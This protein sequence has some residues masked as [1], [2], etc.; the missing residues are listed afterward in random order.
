MKLLCLLPLLALAPA[1]FAAPATTPAPAA[2]T[3][4]GA[5]EQLSE[6]LASARQRIGQDGEVHVAYDVDARGRPQPV[7]VEGTARYRTPVRIAIDSLDCRGGTPQRY[8]LHIRFADRPPTLAA[9]PAPAAAASLAQ[10]A[11]PR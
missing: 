8:V 1:A 4:P 9:A 11:A 7:T 10:A 5:A 2:A 6:Y 3:C